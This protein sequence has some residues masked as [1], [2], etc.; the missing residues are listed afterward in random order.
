MRGA[1]LGPY[2]S[3]KEVELMCLKNKAQYHRYDT[4]EELVNFIADQLAESKV[5]GWFQGRAEFGPRALG[6]RSILGDPRDPDMQK[7]MNLKIKFR[8]QFRPFAPAVLEE[9]KNDYFDM[10]TNSPYMLLVSTVKKNLRHVL[11]SDYDNKSIWDKL[12]SSRSTLNAITHVDFSARIQTV[13]KRINPRFH[14]LIE[15]F[16]KRTNC[17][18]LMNTSFNVRGEP[19]VNTPQEAYDCFRKSDMDILVINNYFFDKDH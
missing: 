9:D 18:V 14:L 12:Y 3:D 13:D 2:Y 17:S 7:K 10:E 15:S 4:F 1:L 5:V 11:D 6:N 19:I 8:E 16:K